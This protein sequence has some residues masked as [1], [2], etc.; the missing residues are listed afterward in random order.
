MSFL[1]QKIAKGDEVDL[2]SKPL[3][4]SLPNRAPTSVRKQFIVAQK[5]GRKQFYLQFP[6]PVTENS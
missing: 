6:S 3:T 5:W 2:I 4:L 1:W